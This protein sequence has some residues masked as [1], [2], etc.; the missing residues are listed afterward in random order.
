MNCHDCL[1]VGTLPV[2]IGS[3]GNGHGGFRGWLEVDSSGDRL[4]GLCAHWETFRKPRSW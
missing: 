3:A 2:L 1:G 4:F